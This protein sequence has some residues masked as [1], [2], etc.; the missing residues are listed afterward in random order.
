MSIE[1][2]IRNAERRAGIETKGTV[3]PAITV[4]LDYGDG[5]TVPH[6]LGPVDQW[7]T[8]KRAVEE[9][10]QRLLPCIFFANPWSEY[11]ARHG[12]EPGTLAKHELCG[13]VPFAELLTAA[14]GRT[15]DQGEQPCTTD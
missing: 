6:F 12:L 9:A 13:K 10:E 2:R 11:E 1:Q 15:V 5:D 8:R 3:I 14:T 7:V 4:Q